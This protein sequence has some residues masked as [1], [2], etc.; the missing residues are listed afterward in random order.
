MSARFP[1]LALLIAAVAACLLLLGISGIQRGDELAGSGAYAPRQVLWAVLGTA[2][3]CASLALPYRS[4][5]GWGYPFYGVCIV[6]LVAVYIFPARN[7]A[8][9]WIPVGPMSLQPSELAKLAY[10][11]ALGRYLMFRRNQRTVWGLIPPF[12]LTIAPVLLILKEPDLGTALLFF[13]VL[14][15]VLY[16][17]GA[18][19]WH[20]AATLCAG[21]AVVPVLWTVMNAEQKSRVTMLM[22]QQDGGAPQTG[23]GYHLHQSKQ[24]LALGGTWG[25]RVTGMPLSDQAAYRLPAGRTDFVYCLVGERWGI[26]GTLGVL[27]LYVTLIGL[28]CWVAART[29]DPFGRLVATGIVAMVG[30]QA[31]VNTAMT[32]GL[33]PITGL[34]LPLMSYGGSS[35]LITFLSLGLLINIALRP[36]YD[37]AGQPFQFDA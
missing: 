7:G 5:R 32:V 22:T 31:C 2:T 33:A 16:A 23:D 35:L 13:P 10:I 25:S 21:L 15:V 19:K 18:R 24:V 3:L 8:R 9:R 28:G 11:L 34:T 20:L 1:I 37:L 6:L 14:F 30:F 27:L 12:L 17:A 36:G 29:R 4:L 26:A